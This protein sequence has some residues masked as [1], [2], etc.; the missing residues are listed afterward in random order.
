[1]TRDE[2]IAAL[3]KDKITPVTAAQATEI[4]DA[5][6]PTDKEL[7]QFSEHFELIDGDHFSFQ[8][9]VTNTTSVADLV[10]NLAWLERASELEY[11]NGELDGAAANLYQNAFFN[12]R[13][14]VLDAAVVQ[15]N[16]KLLLAMSEQWPE[17]AN[18]VYQLAIEEEHWDIV[19]E[20][21]DADVSF[22]NQ[23]VLYDLISFHF[24]NLEPKQRAVNLMLLGGL[25]Q[26]EVSLPI[27][28]ELVDQ[29][30]EYI[31]RVEDLLETLG[32]EID[33]GE[34]FAGVATEFEATVYDLLDH[35]DGDVERDDISELLAEI[36]VSL[37]AA[38][39]SGEVTVVESK[40]TQSPTHS[41]KANLGQTLFGQS[42]QQPKRVEGIID[43]QEQGPALPT[44]N[45]DFHHALK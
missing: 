32:K 25:G 44:G 10:E 45:K 21:L 6:F 1:M 11:V 7:Q 36:D 13:E 41:I 34:G 31:S 39:I 26:E 9:K 37:V 23:E 17:L 28:E 18:R 19:D 14:A 16:V 4:A 42:N 38:S 15:K 30:N 27:K 35:F 12:E 33:M 8:C 24:E 43:Q 22:S 40:Q 2:L 5:W 29:A 20:L 3:Q